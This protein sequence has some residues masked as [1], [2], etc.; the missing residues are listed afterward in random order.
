[1]TTQ[2]ATDRIR[3]PDLDELI[4]PAPLAH[5][6]SPA[7][8]ALGLRG[9]ITWQEAAHVLDAV[10]HHDRAR[11]DLVDLVA[12]KRHEFYRKLGGTTL[13]VAAF[14]AKTRHYLATGEEL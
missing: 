7:L 6:L 4:S 8:A 14:R 2:T 13:S 3:K 9:E 10:E 1:L 5:R 11:E 12:V